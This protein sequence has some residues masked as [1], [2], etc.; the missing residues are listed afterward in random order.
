MIKLAVATQNIG[1]FSNRNLAGYHFTGTANSLSQIISNLLGLMT[2]IAGVSFLIYFMFGA[3]NWITSG[4]DQ[5]KT[6]AAKLTITNALIGLVISVI[7]YP[8]ALLISR[9]IGIPLADPQEL[10]NSFFR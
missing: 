1:K 10:I 4:G 6:Q 8:V 2:I 5:P 9:L 3:V 7:A